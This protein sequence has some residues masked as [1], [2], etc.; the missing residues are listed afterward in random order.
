MRTASC[1][2]RPQMT[3]AT[4][5]TN[6]RNGVFDVDKFEPLRD[7]MILLEGDAF[8][9]AEEIEAAISALKSLSAETGCYRHG[10]RRIC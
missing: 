9:S 1:E 3:V 10:H 5:G 6:R 2:L 7:A 4:G 8:D